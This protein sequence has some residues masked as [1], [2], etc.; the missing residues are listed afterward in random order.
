MRVFFYI[1]AAVAAL[2]LALGFAH[3]ATGFWP[4]SW[5]SRGYSVRGIDVSHHQGL[6]PWEEVKG[7]E[8]RFAFIKAT[9]GTGHTDSYFSYNW[10][11][12][13]RAGLL[14]GAYHFF[15]MG[16]SG[17]EQAEYYISVVPPEAYSLPPVIDIEVSLKHEPYSIRREVEDM[18]EALEAH[19]GKI[20]ILYMDGNTY[21]HVYKGHQP[22]NPIWYREIWYRPLLVPW[23]FWQYSDRGSVPGIQGNVDLNVFRGTLEDLYALAGYNPD[24]LAQPSEDT[25]P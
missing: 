25:E 1:T 7:G 21:N 13:E 19:Y 9:E 22:S 11:G 14:R 5:L 15:S 16:S 4:A 6:I 3:S 8:I 17:K 23:R 18:S 24:W 2:L 20:P 10:Q 12:A